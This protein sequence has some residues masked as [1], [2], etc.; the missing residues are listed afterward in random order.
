[1]LQ[2][3]ELPGANKATSAP[4]GVPE[5]SDGGRV[6]LSSS[7]EEKRRPGAKVPPSFAAFSP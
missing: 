2:Q 7:L 6:T 5:G 1:M 4:L 3:M